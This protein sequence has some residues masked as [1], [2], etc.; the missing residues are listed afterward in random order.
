MSERRS[1]R[2]SPEINARL[3]P[4]AARTTRSKASIARQAIQEYLEDIDD[5]QA[6]IAAMEEHLPASDRLTP[7]DE[8]LARCGIHDSRETF[9]GT[10]L[11]DLFG[12]LE[13]TDED[14]TG[15]ARPIG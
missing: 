8:L 4:L 5:H 14:D 6:A 1:V 9:I 15:P 12:S 10:S 7:N 11:L 13:W 3:D 2:Q